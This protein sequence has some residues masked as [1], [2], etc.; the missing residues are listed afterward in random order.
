MGTA[1]ALS[2]VP[3]ASWGVSK[4]G[5]V[6]RRAV[7]CSLIPHSRHAASAESTAQ[8]S[9]AGGPGPLTPGQPSRGKGVSNPAWRGARDDRSRKMGTRVRKK[10]SL[11]RRICSWQGPESAVFKSRAGAVRPQHR[12]SHPFPGP[13]TFSW[14]WR[15]CS[16]KR[17]ETHHCRVV[18]VSRGLSWGG[19]TCPAGGVRSTGCPRLVE[20]SETEEEGA[21]LARN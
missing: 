20:T 13:S 10:R 2:R 18:E 12:A 16:R 4:T 17:G 8:P 14:P 6:G 15:V 9:P 21:S 5:S 1:T 19:K 11:Q 3:S 7:G